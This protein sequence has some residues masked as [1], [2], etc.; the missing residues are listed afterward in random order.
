MMSPAL[1]FYLVEKAGRT[2]KTPATKIPY[3]IFVIILALMGGLPA[4][5]ALFPQTG[6]LKRD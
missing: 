5:I 3:E 2:P 4:S 6:K 1:V